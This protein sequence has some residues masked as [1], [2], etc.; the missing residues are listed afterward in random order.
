[1][2]NDEGTSP[3]YICG[4]WEANCPRLPRATED[5]SCVTTRYI[6]DSM[7]W[8]G[9]GGQIPKSWDRYYVPAWGS[10]D[11]SDHISYYLVGGGGQTRQQMKQRAELRL[12]NV[13]IPSA[14]LEAILMIPKVAECQRLVR[15]R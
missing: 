1:M 15:C 6:S 9:Q 11:C 13:A 8:P 2:S 3:S 14:A 4:C 12:P 5:V 10:T 7:W